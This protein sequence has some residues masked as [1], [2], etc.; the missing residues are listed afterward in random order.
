M[1]GLF[2]VDVSCTHEWCMTLPPPCFPQFLLCF[3]TSFWWYQCPFNWGRWVLWWES[4]SLGRS[5]SGE[6]ELEC[7][8]WCC[9]VG[10]HCH[11]SICIHSHV[12]GH[13]HLFYISL[14]W[15]SS[16]NLHSFTV[17]LVESQI[18]W[19]NFFLLQC[20]NFNLISSLLMIYQSIYV[21]TLIC[22]HVFWIMN[23]INAIEKL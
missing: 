3:L 15:W 5:L 16:N 17:C 20:T 7:C 2:S 21:L 6:M 1:I 23:K 18:W 8:R 22:G 10:A 9:C 13:W 11:S 12:R 14:V 19:F 4:V